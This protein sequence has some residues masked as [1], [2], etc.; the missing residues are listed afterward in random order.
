MAVVP[1]GNFH[2]RHCVRGVAL[3]I[4]AI[5]ALAGCGSSGASSARHSSVQRRPTWHLVALGDSLPFGQQFCGG[6]RTFVTLFSAGV[7]RMAGVPAVVQNLSEDTGM[8]A[9]ICG[10]RSPRARAVRRHLPRVQRR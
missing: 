2:R 3:V 6:C 5:V 4:V 8:T 10:G 9:G 1:Q 7:Q